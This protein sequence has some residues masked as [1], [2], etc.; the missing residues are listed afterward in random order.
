MYRFVRH[1]A[2]LGSIVQSLGF[3]LLFCSL[4]SILP[5]GI[6]IILFV[7]RTSLEDRVLLNELEGY[8]EYALKTRYRMIP[9]IW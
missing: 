3:P 4:W 5:V 8:A 7:I 1:P 6:L 9:G 2:Y